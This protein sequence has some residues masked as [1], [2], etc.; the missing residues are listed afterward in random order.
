MRPVAGRK[1]RARSFS[2]ALVVLLLLVAV[3][4]LRSTDPAE[5][6]A[7]PPAG[8]SPEHVVQTYLRAMNAWDVETLNALVVG[9]HLRR[10]RFDSRWTVSGISIDSATPESVTGSAAEGWAQAVRVPVTFRTTHAPDVSISEGEEMPWGYILVR[11]DDAHPWRI[12]EQGM[13]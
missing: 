8:A 2:G 11:Q 9:D 7:M 1:F 10:S 5:H 12:I 13:A 4:W 6:V 3:L